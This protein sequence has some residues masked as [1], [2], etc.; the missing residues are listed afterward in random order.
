MQNRTYEEMRAIRT[1]QVAAGRFGDPAE[2]GEYCAY[3][4]SAQAGFITGQNLLIDGGKYP[5]TF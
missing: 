3:L 2:L 4:C 5:G 1:A